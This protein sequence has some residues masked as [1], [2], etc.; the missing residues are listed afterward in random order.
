[1]RHPCTGIYTCKRIF[2]QL[3]YYSYCNIITHTLA[4]GTTKSRR[5]CSNAPALLLSYKWCWT[6]GGTYVYGTFYNS[7]IA[8][9]RKS[10]KY[11]DQTAG[12]LCTLIL[13]INLFFLQVILLGPLYA[14]SSRFESIKHFIVD[15]VS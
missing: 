10:N 5:K 12:G 1:M 14:N 9:T 7:Y 11:I 15:V 2:Q 8:V 4:S 3:A 6:V 13:A